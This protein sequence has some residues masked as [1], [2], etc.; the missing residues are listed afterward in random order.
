MM[1]I[2]GHKEFVRWIKENDVKYYLSNYGCWPLSH[3]EYVGIDRNG[4]C[5]LIE[6]YLAEYYIRQTDEREALA[7]LTFSTYKGEFRRLLNTRMERRR[8]K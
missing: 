1:K 3:N 2:Q 6:R 8:E 4:Q 5:Y 7:S